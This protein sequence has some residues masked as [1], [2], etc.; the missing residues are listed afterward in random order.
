MDTDCKLSDIDYRQIV[1]NVNSIVLFWHK[2]GDILFINDFGSSF[3]GF[4][5]DELIGK[6]VIGTIVPEIET[7]GRDL[8]GLM[9]QICA[10]PENFR[11]NINENTC[12]DGTRCWI[13]W[14][15]L[16]I[17]D[18]HDGLKILSFGNDIT[19]L[20]RSE[21]AL[22]ESERLHR[23][24]FE[25]APVGIIH[26]DTTGT[27]TACNDAFVAI[28]G[29][30]RQSLVGLN[31]LKLPDERVRRAIQ[32]VLDH[33]SG[34]MEGK[35]T[36]VTGK[37]TTYVNATF[38]PI[39]SQD[40]KLTGGMGIIED[41]TE[42]KV[43]EER[44]K[45]SEAF[46]KRIF[47]GSRVPIV[48]MDAQTYCF[49]DCNQA[50]VDIYRFASKQD[51]VG[52]RPLDFSA[53]EQYDGTDSVIKAN[54]YII[55]AIEE[56]MVVFEWLHQRPDGERWDAEVHLMSFQADNRQLL[57]FTLHDITHRKQLEEQ[58]LQSQKLEAVGR[59]AGGVAHDFNN[60]LQIITS[61]SELALS[62]CDPDTK[63]HKLLY[64]VYKA[65]NRSAELTKQL[66]AFARKQTVIPKLI[67]LNNN[68]ENMINMLARLIKDGIELS[69]HPVKEEALVK[70]DPVQLDQL[71][72]N[73]VVNANDAISGIGKIRIRTELKDI[74]GQ[75]ADRIGILP[76]K[77][78]LLS[79]SDT[80]CGMD[81]NMLKHIFE[82]FYT[83]K[84][85]GEGTGLGLATVYGIV[86]QNSGGITVQSEYG[87]GTTF[88][89]YLPCA[90]GI[91]A[92]KD[93]SKNDETIPSQGETIL[94]VEDEF[95]TLKM[96]ENILEMLGYKV[97]SADTPGKAI[98]LA[99]KEIER[100]DMVLTDV[101]MPEMNGREMV[102]V[103]ISMKPT[104]KRLYMSGYPA[105]VICK[106]GI[107]E[108]GVDLLQKPFKTATLS[109]KLRELLDG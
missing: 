92:D 77:Y 16:P 65:G 87:S 86:K 20:K 93:T 91:D 88:E 82:P 55:K 53:P 48:I 36:S 104:L 60:M 100:I 106:Q 1:E 12:K 5:K 23:I 108:D 32:D 102:D 42:K 34:F 41:I 25:A 38:V 103:L 95:A 26:F 47:E 43:V 94:L 90:Q 64:Q 24:L 52:K 7:G 98:A 70:L 61:C 50:A 40:M 105:E 63:L 83:T 37:K 68:I 28:M 73:L 96:I 14:L 89:I 57:Q 22:I 17:Y 71:L 58:L 78:I 81:M 67:D 51:V 46:L 6:H 69:W 33:K 3:F 72:V 21:Q 29:S 59:L 45:A 18:E 4:S 74:T 44:L 62:M 49:L 8:V 75:K 85:Q 13:S 11:L 27:I 10:H 19:Q 79:V 84:P 15:N 30:S 54:D 39:I 2:S 35:Y 107:L 56:G 9:K 66:L 99:A 80:G 109:Q 97:F 76:G 101:L 31:M